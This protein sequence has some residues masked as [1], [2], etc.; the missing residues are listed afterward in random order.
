MESMKTSLFCI[1][2]GKVASKRALF[3]AEDA[4]KPLKNMDL[5]LAKII[6][7]RWRKMQRQN[8]GVKPFLLWSLV[9]RAKLV[10]IE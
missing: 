1:L 8:M 7:V 4:G 10:A 5:Q 3:Y 2:W 6:G 9:P